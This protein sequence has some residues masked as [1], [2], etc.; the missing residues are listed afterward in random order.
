MVENINI[1]NETLFY[2]YNIKYFYLPCKHFHRL[3]HKE[4]SNLSHIFIFFIQHFLLIDV[5]TG[6]IAKKNCNLSILFDIFL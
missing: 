2:W 5:F 1:F 6:P 4:I 3:H